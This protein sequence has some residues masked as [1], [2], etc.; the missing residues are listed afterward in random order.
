M[1]TCWIITGEHFDLAATFF[2]D[3]FSL[4][5]GV[6]LRLDKPFSFL[7]LIFNLA[8]LLLFLHL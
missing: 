6:V 3:N 8:F 7:H 4:A 2:G 5:F 1:G